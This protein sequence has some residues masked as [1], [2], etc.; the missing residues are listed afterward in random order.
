MTNEQI[1]R[2]ESERLV[3][4]GVLKRIIVDG[5]EIPEPIHTFQKWKSLGYCVKKGEK[6][7]IKIPIWKCASKK[8][9][10]ENKEEEVSSM[11]MKTAAFFTSAQV[12][13]IS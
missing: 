12:D 3:A 5:I 4:D 11:F 9:K 1:I 13:K 6:S 2:K 8:V 7:S 10:I